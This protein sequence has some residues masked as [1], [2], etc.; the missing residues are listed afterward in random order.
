MKNFWNVKENLSR[1][2]QFSYRGLFFAE[3]PKE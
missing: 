2:F 3:F 1:D